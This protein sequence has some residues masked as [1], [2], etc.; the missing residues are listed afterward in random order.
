MF[1]E[2]SNNSNIILNSN[3]NQNNIIYSNTPKRLSGYMRANSQSQ[4]KKIPRP[5]IRSKI[6]LPKLRTLTFIL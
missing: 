5:A 3:E 4:T 2:K 1:P 6:I